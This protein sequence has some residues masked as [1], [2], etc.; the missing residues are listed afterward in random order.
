[1]ASTAA[2]QLLM[3]FFFFF[4]LAEDGSKPTSTR[5]V[6]VFFLGGCTFTEITALRFLGKLRGMCFDTL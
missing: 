2:N 5:V 1:M 4:R 6:M 3:V